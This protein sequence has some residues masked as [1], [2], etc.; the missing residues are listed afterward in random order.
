MK[1]RLAEAFSP[2]EYK[3]GHAA[4]L[5]LLQSQMSVYDGKHYRYADLAV[6]L[7]FMRAL[8]MIHHSHHWQIMGKPFYGDHQLLKQLYEAVQD[9]ID[10]VG[11]K[12]V[13][14][15]SPALTNYFLQIDHMRAFMEKVSDK[16][17]S[18]LL[19]S[20]LSEFVFIQVGELVSKRLQE[21]GLFTSGLANMMGDILDRHETHV[22]LLKQRL[23]LMA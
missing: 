4:A 18:P 12:I 7:A 15:D 2:Q 6:W 23:Q 3:Q 9:E 17:K 16:K 20:L 21:A 5:E 10:K 14:L 13:G 19:V 11:E 8:T 22:Y 1:R